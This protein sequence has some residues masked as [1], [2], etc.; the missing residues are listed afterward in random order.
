MLV[1][2]SPAALPLLQGERGVCCAGDPAEAAAGARMFEEGG[3]AMDAVVAAAFMGFVVEQLDCGLGGFA[4]VSARVSDRQFSVEGYVRAPAAATADMFEVDPA[5][6]DTYYGHPPTRGDAARCGPLAVAVPGAVA[7]LCRAHT[8]GGRLPLAAVLEP[9][10]EQARAGIPVTWRDVLA[11]SKRLPEI[12]TRPA[13]AQALLVDGE[14]P[15]LQPQDPAPLTRDGTAL[16]RTLERIAQH[17]PS[18]FYEGVIASILGDAIQ[19][20]GGILRASDLQRFQPTVGEEV[21]VEY[22]DYRCTTC[23]DHVSYEALQILGGFDMPRLD[24]NGVEAR[25]LMA[26]ALAIAFTDGITHYEDPRLGSP[27]HEGLRSPAFAAQRRQQLRLDRAAPRPMTPGDPWPHVAADGHGGSVQPGQWGWPGTSQMVAADADGNV[28]SVITA[29]GWDYGSLVFVEELGLFLN[30]A[31]SYFDP[32][33][34]RRASVAPDKT[35][36]FGAPTLVAV[37]AAA[38]RLGI[39]GSGGYRIQTAVLH[40]LSGVVDFGL[41]LDASIAQPRVHC[42]GRET[43]VDARI[44]RAVQEALSGLGHDVVV[45]TEDP[46]SWHFGRVCAVQVD[47]DGVRGSAGPSW[48]TAAAAV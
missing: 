7:G 27:V 39:A 16:S 25:H 41:P 40:A 43:I 2:R 19:R 12:R 11:I 8:L 30:N 13:A 3:N 48:T 45:A 18:A 1:T 24:P 44:D 46:G 21:P 22:R 36:M 4:Q 15:R 10:I 34:G 23:F 35:P 17:G 14:V 38:E 32:R 6:G 26:E 47:A 31:M 9:A 20:S 29:V 37:G 5:A 42:Q 33:P 28:A